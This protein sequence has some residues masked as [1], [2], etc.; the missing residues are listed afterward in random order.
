[1]PGGLGERLP[2]PSGL[3]S[4]ALAGRVAARLQGLLPEPLEERLA[5]VLA[6]VERR[7]VRA[8]GHGGVALLL[9]PADGSAD[10]EEIASAAAE[11][12]V[13]SALS[14]AAPA[15]SIGEPLLALAEAVGHSGALALAS[16]PASLRPVSGWQEVATA[17]STLE[18]FAAGALAEQT[19]WTSRRAALASAGRPGGAPPALAQAAAGLLEC[20]GTPAELAARP[21]TLLEAWSHYEGKDCP[22]MPR[23]LRRALADPARA[24]FPPAGARSE[25]EAV[26][27]AARERLV[28]AG[29]AT[30]LPSGDFSPTQALVLAARA[31]SAGSA[32]LCTW[33]A[34]WTVAPRA[35]T[36]CR[37]DEPR[38][39]LLLS[40][41]R[42]G[43]GFE[44]AWV[45]QDGSQHPVV[46]W[47]RWVLSPT[48]CRQGSSVCFI[49]PRGV[50]SVSL[51]GRT[52][53]ALLASGSYRLLAASP[54]R[55]R[56]AA[57]RWPE[58]EVWLADERG[59]GVQIPVS[60]H[61]GLAWVDRDVLAVAGT[62]HIGLFSPSGEGR[63]EALAS[64][65]TTAISARA[66][67]VYL[68]ASTPSGPALVRV[69][70]GT[71]QRERLTSAPGDVSSLHASPDGSLVMATSLG[72][73]RWRPGEAALRFSDGLSVGP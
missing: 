14:P 15:E 67:S 52:P 2:L 37:D 51:D 61:C 6:A 49:D 24:G 54:D 65:A 4:H 29:V 57:A 59:A 36:G 28:V 11:A 40:R 31:R 16:L 17:R 47:P 22:K 62:T 12:L 38:E 9:V 72:L 19:P 71:G 23:V 33:L 34:A 3:D 27:V 21:Q 44:V 25:T 43:H 39:G 70:L 55:T 7:G 18:S 64:P 58:A 26:R 45:A 41:P 42:P 73:W 53:P 10:A 46:I 60:G 20:L 50:W 69:D 63:A 68:A 48:L 30:P 1:M 56:L 35:L 32:G 8:V 66:G 13:A 5:V